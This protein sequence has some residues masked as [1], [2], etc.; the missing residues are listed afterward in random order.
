MVRRLRPALGTWVEVQANGRRGAPVPEAA[1]QAAYAA[2]AKVEA[3]MSVHRPDS[4]LSRLN[5][6]RPG[7]WMEAD[8]WTLEVLRLSQELGEASSWAFDLRSGGLLA[9]WGMIPMPEAASMGSPWA[10]GPALEFKGRRLRKTGPWILD[11]GGIAKGY[12]VDQAVKALAPSSQAGC[13]N[14]GGDLRLWGAEMEV[15]VRGEAWARNLKGM[16]GS[17]AS[18]TVRPTPEK[19]SWHLRPSTQRPMLVKRTATVFARRCAVADALTKVVLLAKPALARRC[20][21]AQ[22]AKAMLFNEQ[23][24]LVEAYG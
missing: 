19:R 2:I 13:I 8:A 7:E 14:A 18:S 10:D 5:R 17:V 16:G 6:C 12:A 3:L 24:G 9:R 1:L 20:L 4:E 23:G 11:L 21:Q 22:G 15:Q